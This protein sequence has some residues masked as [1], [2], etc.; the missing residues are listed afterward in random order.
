MDIPDFSDR[1]SGRELQL[2]EAGTSIADGLQAEARREQVAEAAEAAAVARAAE[3]AE[4]R[5]R[6]ERLQDGDVDMEAGRRER[7][8]ERARRVSGRERVADP[9]ARSRHA[10]RQEQ[11]RS[12]EAAVNQRRGQV[13]EAARNSDEEG[14]DADMPQEKPGNGHWGGNGN[15]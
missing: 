3:A 6:L 14:Q 11:Q 2:P 8:P 5:G 10:S 15:W 12:R 13:E 4:A 7:A 9:T 1:E